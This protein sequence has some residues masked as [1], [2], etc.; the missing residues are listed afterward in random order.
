[1]NIFVSS[2]SEDLQDYRAVARNVILDVGWH[3]EM[4]EHFGA[5]P[6]PT[7][8]ACHEVLGR[9]ELV[10]LIVA[11]RRGWV[12]TVEQG[13]NEV[14]SITA[15]ELAHA[16][17]SDIPVLAMFASDMWPGKLWENDDPEARDWIQKFRDELNL[18]AVF[19]DP[20]PVTTQESERLPAFRAKVKEVLL[21]HRERLLA[22]QS[23]EP[24][25][26]DFFE[27]ARQGLLGGTDIP[28]LGTGSH[29][30]GPLSP[31]ALAGAL[32]GDLPP[33]DLLSL[34]T[35][36]EY[37]ER[38]VGSRDVFLDQFGRVLAEQEKQIAA[39]PVHDLVVE[40]DNAPLIV[41]ASF[42]RLL[43]QRFDAAGKP[44][45][46]V[47][48]I[49]RSDERQHDGRILVV[50]GEES[51]EIFPADE[52][53]VDVRKERVIYKPLGSPC[54]N[55]LL[56]ELEPDLDLDTVVVT[57]TDHLTFLGRLESPRTGIPTIFSRLLRKR[58]LLFLGY[59]MDVWQYR[60]VMEVFQSIGARR[61]RTTTLAVRKPASPMEEMA[62][63][64]LNAE[65]VPMDTD[66]FARRLMAEPTAS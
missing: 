2:T 7:V 63:K 19:F 57:E 14:D 25:G 59:A 47:T 5:S 44:Y 58:P 37:R 32:G 8:A 31:G 18:P 10:L 53:E 33:E 62:W 65:L 52:V 45:V 17:E 1:M 40:L 20:E 36:A 42:D 30:S 55:V 15:I 6:D 56:E 43:E 60:L 16:R 26:I 9:C 27:R 46:L 4:M 22:R 51:A 49:L 13:G 48:H 12:P 64:R 21:A 35:A 41:S 54:L 38:F 24:A 39:S 66:E 61:K 34:A 28:F 23:A 29:N 50:R 3:P 11:Y